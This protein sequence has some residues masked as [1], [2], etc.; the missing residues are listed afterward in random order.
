MA[1]VAAPDHI[2]VVVTTVMVPVAAE[3]VDPE[4][5]IQV[6]KV[7]KVLEVCEVDGDN[8]Q[9]KEIILEK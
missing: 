6:P 4:C 3:V 7:P 9:F 2:T 8:P 1:V 5:N